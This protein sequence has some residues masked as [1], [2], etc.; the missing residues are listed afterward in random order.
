MFSDLGVQVGI[1]LLTD[2][3]AAK[4]IAM[5]IGLGKVRHFETS[6]LWLQSKV[7]SGGI[8]VQKIDGKDNVAD[9][10]TKYLSGPDMTLHLQMLPVWR[11]NKVHPK[12]VS[13]TN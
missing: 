11:N 12:S 3:S 10:L 8:S 2:A 4:G 9:A 5:R 1:D 6:Q 13:V 7:L